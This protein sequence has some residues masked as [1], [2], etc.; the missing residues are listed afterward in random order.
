MVNLVETYYD[1]VIVG[2]PYHELFLIQYYVSI[3]AIGF[4][5]VSQGCVKW[6]NFEFPGKGGMAL[7]TLS[8]SQGDRFQKRGL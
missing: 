3:T 1:M 2:C 5:G 7:K 4:L 6:G 8:L